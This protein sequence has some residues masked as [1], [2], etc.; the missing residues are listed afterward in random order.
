MRVRDHHHGGVLDDGGDPDGGHR[1]PA[2]RPHALARGDEL[3]GPLH[4][5]PQGNTPLQL[6]V[7]AKI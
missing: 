6:A 1:P 4:Q 5:L 7:C 3:G 2:H